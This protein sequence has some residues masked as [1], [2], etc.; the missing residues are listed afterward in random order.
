MVVI[1]GL[2]FFVDSSHEVFP[3]FVSAP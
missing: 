3:P 1:R 2:Q